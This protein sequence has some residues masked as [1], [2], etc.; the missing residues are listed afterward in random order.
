MDL[1]WRLGIIFVVVF[2]LIYVLVSRMRSKPGPG[3]K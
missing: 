1:N 3:G 2:A